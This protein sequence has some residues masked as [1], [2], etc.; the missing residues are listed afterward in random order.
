VLH[1]DIK[2][3]NIML[4]GEGEI[5]VGDFGLAIDTTRCGEGGGW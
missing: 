3:E 4:S 2:P 5:K 1:R